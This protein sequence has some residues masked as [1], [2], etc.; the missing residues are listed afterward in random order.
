MGCCLTPSMSSSSLGP[1]LQAMPVAV[2]QL[3]W[4][5]GWELLHLTGKQATR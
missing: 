1:P 2:Q 5:P 4:Q 3:H